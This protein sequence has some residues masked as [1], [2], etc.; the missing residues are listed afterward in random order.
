MDRDLRI[1]VTLEQCWHRIPGG[2][3]RATV[4]TTTALAVLAA[5][6][7][8]PFEP[9]TDRR[10]PAAG[11]A[12]ARGL[13]LVGVAAAHR[14]Q[15]TLPLPPVPVR[16][17]HLPRRAL[18]EGWH[19]LRRP[20][21]TTVTGPV[22]AIWASALAVPPAE[23]PLVATVH[24]LA[25]LDD[26]QWSTPRGLSF[27]RRSWEATV[28]RASI[29]VV[30]SATTARDCARHGLEPER[31]LVVP[32]GVDGTRAAPA[33][34]ERVRRDLDL[35]DRFVLWV[36]T[37]EPRKNLAGLTDA[38]SRL[39]LPLVVVGPSGWLVEPDAVLARLGHRARILGP[40]EDQRLRAV[41]AA[42]TVFAL[43]SL[44]E[45]FGLPVLEAMAQ[46]TPV[47]TSSGTATADVAGDTAVLVDPRDPAALAA[48][49][50]ELAEDEDRRQALGRAGQDRAARF[51]WRA[52][53]QGYLDAFRR[54]ASRAGAR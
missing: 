38:L 1:A 29:V 9:R 40:L 27:F 31:V 44:A 21:V 49:I 4:A 24:D 36:G 34:V 48:A 13:R 3:G 47:V 8:E 23:V 45:G 42:A 18:Y 39:D 15:P 28:Q 22:D 33:E 30:P 16:H 19:R 20:R 10:G 54:A 6:P 46:G 32:W 11:G 52:T 2:V 26:P 37:A 17:H 5:E 51:T 50:G 7:L 25:F 53:A 35:P 43:P 41:Y 12:P 14:T